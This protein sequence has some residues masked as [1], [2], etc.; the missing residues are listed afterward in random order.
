MYY[1][2]IVYPEKKTLTPQV[3]KCPCYEDLADFEKEDVP[4]AKQEK[5]VLAV[6]DIFGTG[7]RVQIAN[8]LVRVQLHSR[9]YKAWH[10]GTG[11][12]P[13]PPEQ[14]GQEKRKVD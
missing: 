3:S 6:C 9:E 12:V 11:C 10:P 13:S 5:L 4:T 8:A 2:C 7:A 14:P 1:L